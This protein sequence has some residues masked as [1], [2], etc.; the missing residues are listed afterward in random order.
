M[1]RPSRSR[2]A[3]LALALLAPGASLAA[4]PDPLDVLARR[5]DD[6]RGALAR[7]PL[8]APRGSE[9]ARARTHR[10][11][12]LALLLESQ[13]EELLA[14]AATAPATSATLASTRAQGARLEA[15]ELA[16]ADRGSPGESL[17]PVASRL[18]AALEDAQRGADV[19]GLALADARGRGERERTLAL[20]QD[21]L[22][23]AAGAHAELARVVADH[24]GSVLVLGIAPEHAL[25][26]ASRARTDDDAARAAL[27]ARVPGLALAT[28]PASVLFGPA[29]ASLE[30]VLDRTGRVRGVDLAGAERESLVRALQSEIQE[31]P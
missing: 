6:A 28:V 16:L 22:A 18:A 11:R 13:A 1:S 30:L 24:R 4:E 7:S 9:R 12:E 27:A 26:A 15:L 19:F 20:V 2:H 23:R 10:R 29:D 17:A 31:R 3:A 25:A 8:A 21:R 14:Y 5:L